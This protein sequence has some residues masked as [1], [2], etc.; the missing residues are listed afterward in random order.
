MKRNGSASRAAVANG[1]SECDD[2]FGDQVPVAF[3]MRTDTLGDVCACFAVRIHGGCAA[4]PGTLSLVRIRLAQ[5]PFLPV[6]ASTLEK[7]RDADEEKAE[8]RAAWFQPRLNSVCTTRSAPR[9]KR[10]RSTI[11]VRR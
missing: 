11:P 1:R 9:C 3:A 10:G 8:P 4:R 2:G 5:L 7:V 6:L